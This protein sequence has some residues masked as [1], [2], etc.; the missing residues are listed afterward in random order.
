[1][2]ISKAALIIE[3]DNAVAEVIKELLEGEGVQVILAED[4]EHSKAKHFALI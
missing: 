1:M 2:N 3:D 4:R